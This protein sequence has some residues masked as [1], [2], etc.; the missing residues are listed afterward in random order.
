MTLIAVESHRAGR[1]L[2]APRTG[3]FLDPDVVPVHEIERRA[4]NRRAYRLARRRQSAASPSPAPR[5]TIGLPAS[6]FLVILNWPLYVSRRG[7]AAR[8]TPGFAAL[9]AALN[10]LERI[11]RRTGQASRQLPSPGTT[12]SCGRSFRRDR[13]GDDGVSLKRLLGLAAV[14]DRSASVSASYAVSG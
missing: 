10:A 2:C 7:A 1:G 4:R 5:K 12:W 11:V 8:R 14:R 6:P 9:K 3:N 13:F